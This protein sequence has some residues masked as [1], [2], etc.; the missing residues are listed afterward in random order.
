[1][2]NIGKQ[3]QLVT[4]HEGGHSEHL[5][6]SF[7]FMKRNLHLWPSKRATGEKNRRTIT[8]VALSEGC[9]NSPDTL[10]MRNSSYGHPV[11]LQFCSVGFKQCGFLQ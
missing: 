3:S 7:I 1:M 9:R 5:S 10:Y 2:A 8:A 4:Q 6:P 11:P